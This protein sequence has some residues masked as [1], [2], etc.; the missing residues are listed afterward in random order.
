MEEVKRGAFRQ[1]LYYRLLGLP[2]ELPPL[3]E[4]GNDILI[5][6]KHFACQFCNENGMEQKILSNKAL[7][8]LL[9]HPFPGNIRELK[10]VIELAVTLADDAE[11]SD[12]NI[13]L[14]SGQSMP[15][16]QNGEL[17]LREYEMRI[18]QSFLQKYN[19]NTKLVAEK[20]DI[21]VATI[22]RMLKEWKQE[23]VN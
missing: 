22:Y 23:Q 7:N 3:R 17:T 15:D 18:V 4:R 2:I 21:G 1:D 6:A 10:S 8:K 5:L 16:I 9:N 19:N 13:V 20:L 14:G 12:E 11:I